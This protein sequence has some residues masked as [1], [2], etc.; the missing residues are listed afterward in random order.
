MAE[1]YPAQAISL[2]SASAETI[3]LQ[4]EIDGLMTTIGSVDIPSA[5]NMVHPGAV[6]MHEGLVFL[7][8]DLD[9]ENHIAHLKPTEVDYYTQPG[10]RQQSY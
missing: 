1:G 9:L 5:P 4:S 8:E 6:Y 3:T 2:R 10:V 7:V